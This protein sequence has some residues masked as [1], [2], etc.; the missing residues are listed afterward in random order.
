MKR[1]NRLW[2]R[3]RSW[4]SPGPSWPPETPKVETPKYGEKLP[5]AW[6]VGQVHFVQSCTMLEQKSERKSQGQQRSPAC[7]GLSGSREV[8]I[9]Y[10]RQKNYCKSLLFARFNPIFNIIPQLGIG[11]KITWT[12]LWER[13]TIIP[14]R[15]I[16]FITVWKIWNNDST[17]R[18]RKYL[19]YKGEGEVH[20]HVTHKVTDLLFL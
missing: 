4:S 11:C 16:S 7:H 15:F 2:S 5:S 8:S 3:R 1:L 10:M 9:P 17:I 12:E 14:S 18:R 13:S 20:F 19:Q 6:G